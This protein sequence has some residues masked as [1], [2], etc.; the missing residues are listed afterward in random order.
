MIRGPS[1]LLGVT[2][3]SPIQYRYLSGKEDLDTHPVAAAEY[4]HT[5]EDLLFLRLYVQ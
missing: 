4:A 1:A 5:I 3:K 2:Q